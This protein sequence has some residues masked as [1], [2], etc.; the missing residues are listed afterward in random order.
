MLR[1]VVTL[2]ANNGI[3]T[4]ALSCAQLF[5]APLTDGSRGP[6]VPYPGGRAHLPR[7]RRPAAGGSPGATT[8]SVPTTA[9]GVTGSDRQTSPLTPS[10]AQ[11]GYYSELLDAQQPGLPAGT[12][13]KARKGATTQKPTAARLFSSK[14]AQSV[15]AVP[16]EAAADPTAGTAA[17]PEAPLPLPEPKVYVPFKQEIGAMPRRVVVERARR[18]FTEQDLDAL[19]M[20]HGVD[21]TLAE[22]EGSLALSSF[23]DTDFESRPISEWASLAGE[24][25]RGRY[26]HRAAAGAKVRLIYSCKRGAQVRLSSSCKLGVRVNSDE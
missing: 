9:A 19:L 5:P 17:A 18:M 6:T 2:P 14:S 7:G 20:G 10:R 4:A 8:A 12:H 25:L 1:V 26:M 3:T 11:R 23:D 16:A 21:T 13:A 24:S 15:A 22:P